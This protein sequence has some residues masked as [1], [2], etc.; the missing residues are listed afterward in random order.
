MTRVLVLLALL[1][2]IAGIADTFPLGP[3]ADG[4]ELLRLLQRN[5]DEFRTSERGMKEIAAVAA[6]RGY[7]VGIAVML[8]ERQICVPPEQFK[9]T[10][11]FLVVRAY[12]EQNTDKLAMT[13]S[14]LTRLALLKAF[15]CK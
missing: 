8:S 10:T 7:V 4:Y 15:P 12:L 11:T 6:A 2:P 3:P 5:D 13:A 9:Q 1:I 14:E